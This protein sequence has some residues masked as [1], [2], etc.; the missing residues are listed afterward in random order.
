[1]NWK[2]F[3]YFTSAELPT[4]TMIILMLSG[5]Q[6]HAQQ[7]SILFEED[8]SL[9]FGIADLNARGSNAAHQARFDLYKQMGIGVL[10]MDEGKWRDFELQPNM[11]QFPAADLDF[12][13]LA[14][15]NG[16]H[17][18]SNI[19]AIDSPAR[20]FLKDHPDAQMTNEVGLTSFNVISYWY[21]G[22][23]DLLEDKDDKI[24]SF[25]AQQGLL[26]NV[27]FLIVP[28][29]P[30]GEPVYP[31]P[32]TTSDPNGTPHFWFYDPHAQA[33]FPVKMQAQYGSISR[34]NSVWGTH[35][36][37]WSTVKLPTPG[38]QPGPMWRDVLTWYRD[39][40]RDFIVWQMS[41]YQRLLAKYWPDG[42]KPK[43]MILV[44]GTHITPYEWTQAIKFGGGDPGI[45]I[46]AD[47][48]FL[49]DI[50][51]RF[52]AFTQYTGLPNITE[53]EYLQSY[54]RSRGYSVPM[55]GENA[56]N[57]GKPQELGYE[58]LGNGLVGQEYIGSNLFGPDQLTPTAKFEDLSHEFLWLRSVRTGMS[59]FVL[60]TNTVTIVQGTCI[61]NDL[62]GDHRICMQSDGNLV[63]F[64]AS[65]M[66]WSSK[67]PNAKPGLCMPEQ[68]PS[69]QCTAVFQGDGNLVIYRGK[70]PLWASNTS[71]KGK[72][73]VFFDKTP[74]VK[75]IDKVG[76]IVWRPQTVQ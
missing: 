51:A 16:F 11:W 70:Q 54:I 44:P 36:A 67:T 34:A 52:G 3:F 42:N 9:R 20:W 53:V 5:M 75:I 59:P 69:Y 65:G 37:G 57:Q 73:L 74:Y 71:N 49:I 41:H 33:D 48:E 32:W 19:G 27:S 10:R 25:L 8:V 23:H 24:F 14:R 26:S 1:M 15:R 38:T 31:A 4:L 58:V 66:L 18:K 17:F 21:P 72:T 43:L 62:N 22:L 68:G 30:A 6:V 40:K 64:G 50:A 55:W 12:L 60:S 56:G 13:R 47:S 2:S 39:T 76:T 45:I 46:M 29:G 7:T 28:F 63:I 61:N 35:Y